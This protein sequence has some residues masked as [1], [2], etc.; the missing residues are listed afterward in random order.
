MDNHNV[1][2]V[3]SDSRSETVYSD[4][5]KTISE[6]SA[7]A[8]DEAY[9]TTASHAVEHGAET[10]ETV[11]GHPSESL[12]SLLRTLRHRSELTLDQVASEIG[13]SKPTVWAWEKG[14]ANPARSKWQAIAEVLGV[15][16]NVLASA[17]KAERA[18]KTAGLLPAREAK[19]RTTLLAAARQTIA[20]AYGV[21]PSA[22]RITVEI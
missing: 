2:Y 19:D 20:S 17:A 12:G 22:V 14:R 1:P 4:I 11:L 10:S 7:D 13:V 21:T 15:T 5:D 9:E 3:I 6:I 8:G 16:V 18:A